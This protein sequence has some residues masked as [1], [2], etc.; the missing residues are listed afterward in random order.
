MKGQIDKKAGTEKLEYICSCGE[1]VTITSKIGDK[2]DPEKFI[3]GDYC[4]RCR[5]KNS[6]E[7][8]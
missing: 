3:R 4:R 7:V 5:E 2:V 8:V 1:K 6:V